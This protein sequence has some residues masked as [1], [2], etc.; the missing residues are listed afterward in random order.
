[1]A[2]SVYVILNPAAGQRRRE[3]LSSQIEEQFTAAGWKYIIHELAESENISELTHEVVSDDVDLVVAAGGDGTVCGVA[4]GLVGSGIPMGVIPTGTGNVLAQDLGIPI[5]LKGSLALLVGPHRLRSID[6]MKSI[7]TEQA[8]SHYYFLNMSIGVTSAVMVDTDTAQK[9]HLGLLA[10]ILAVLR[11]LAGIQPVQF[12]LGVDD[13]RYHLRAA[14]IVIANS[15]VIGLLPLR[16]DGH[17]ALDDG[18]VSVC[19]IRAHS[20][21]SY[22]QKFASALISRN[23]SHSIWCIP[24]HTCVSIHA[25]RPLAVQADGDPIGVQQV[26]ILI[27]PHAVSIIVP[28]KERAQ[29]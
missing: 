25:D 9:R 20:A 17:I 3:A 16:L 12:D 27:I 24:A 13:H 22:V 2:R 6:A 8:R 28:H 5:S 14:D 19:V 10:Y 18:E 11:K 4:G 26:E 21:V 29:A 7:A 15:G 23:R 1:V